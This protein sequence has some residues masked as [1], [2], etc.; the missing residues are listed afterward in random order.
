MSPGLL[1]VLASA[2]AALVFVAVYSILS[3][4]FWRDAAR[5]NRR[6]DEE[7]QTQQE[8]RARQGLLFKNLAAA[9]AG[10]DTS[11]RR[12]L[13][14]L[15]AQSGLELEPSRLLALTAAAALSITFLALLCRLGLVAAI[16]L[17]LV[18]AWGPLG[19]VLLKRKRRLQ[20][21]MH[22]LPDAFDLMARVIRAGQTMSQALQAIADEFEPPIATEFSYCYEQM[23]LGL[24]PEVVLRE[25]AQRT[26]VLEIKIFVLALLIQT[27]T[28]GNL[29][30]MLDNLA[31]VIR[32]RFKIKGKIQA[33]TAEG[34]LQAVV[35]LALPPL[36]YLVI[37]VINRSYGEVLLAHPGLLV[38]MLVFEALGALWIRK[39]VNF[40][41]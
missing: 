17:G 7:F 31:G 18:G 20:K 4:L 19:Y 11:L 36:L 24:P 38:G 2:A 9:E 40:D 32:E 1:T 3:D 15:I 13:Q 28:G 26:G 5:V 10:E 39:I 16:L 23:N 34:R 25:L 29:A 8:E 12:R 30:E 14:V 41:Y 33:L 6:V 21:L 35:L 22:Q 27:Q 37:L